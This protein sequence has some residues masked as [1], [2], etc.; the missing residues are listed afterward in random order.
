MSYLMKLKELLSEEDFNKVKEDL[1]DRHLI[2]ND[3]TYIPKDKFDALSETKKSLETQLSDM[4]K[5]LA[6]IEP[7]IK[8]NEELKG[9]IS[10]LR[11]GSEKATKELEDK[12]TQQAFNF[13]LETAIQGS[14]A[15]NVKSVLAN[16]DVSKISLDGDNLI[17]FDEQMKG[18]KESDA[19]LFGET[20]IAGPLHKEGDPPAFFTREQV[21]GMTQEETIKNMDAIDKSMEKW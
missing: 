16:L 6:D 4:N 17:G 2:V 12:L 9:Q 11:T 10:E 7:Q 1:G 19:Y 13:K 3:G 15:K 20:K 8:E 21:A 14:G 18:L 5:K